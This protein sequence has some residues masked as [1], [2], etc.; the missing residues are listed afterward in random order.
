MEELAGYDPELV[1]GVLGG[2]SGTTHDCLKLL[3][4][5]RKYG[6]RIALF[7]RKINLAEDPLGLIVQMRR[8]ADGAVTPAEAVRLYHDGLAK[9]RLRALRPLEDDLQV[10]DSVLQ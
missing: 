3:H 5:S 1:V 10:T 8:V 9:Q 2:A 6:A 7:G 4:D